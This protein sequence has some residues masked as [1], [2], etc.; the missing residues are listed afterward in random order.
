[1]AV[2]LGLGEARCNQHTVVLEV[3]LR[4]LVYCLHMSE[5]KFKP[6]CSHRAVVGMEVLDS[7]SQAAA[8]EDNPNNLED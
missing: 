5:V 3:A 1:V 7:Q 2:S 6:G 8:E 4:M